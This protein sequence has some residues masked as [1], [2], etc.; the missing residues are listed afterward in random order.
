MSRHRNVRGYNYDE[1][2]EDD[3]MYGQSVDDDY[4]CISPATANQFIY[5]RQ[6]RQPPKEEPLEEEEYEDEDVPMSPTISHNLDPLDQAKLYSCLDHMRTVLGDAVPDSVLSQAAIRYGF[7]SQKALDAVLSEDTK[8]APVKRSTN[9]ETASVAG[10]SQEK[11]PLPQRTKREPVADKGA[12][13]FASHT[14]ITSKAHNP[15]PDGCKHSQ[16]RTPNLHDHLSQ[17]KADL[18]VSSSENLNV[19]RQNVGSGVSSLAQLMSEHEQKSNGTAVVDTGRGLGVPPL[20][21]LAIGPNSPPSTTSNPNSLSLGT[22]ASLNMSSASHSSA[23]SLLSVSL[24]SLSLNCPKLTTAGSSVAAPPGFGNLTSVLQSNPLLVGVATGGKTTVADPKGSPSLAD[25]IQEHSNHSPTISNYFPTPH[26]S[27]ISV[28]CQGMAAPAQTFSLS[29]LASQ[30]QNRSLHIQSQSQSTERLTD[31]LTLSKPPNITATCQGGT[32]SLSQQALQHQTSS[33]LASPQPVNTESTANALKQP[34]GLSELLSLS[35]LASEHKGKTSTTSYGLQFSLTSLLSPAKP[36]RAG[37]LAESTSECGIKCKLDHKSNHQ[38]SRQPNLGQTI[39]LSELMAQSH[40][41]GPR[42]SNND[43]PSLSCPAPGSSAQES[44]VF[45]TPSVFAATL[46]TQ[47][48]RQQ[49]M[50]RNVLKGKIRSQRTGSGYQA[51]LCKSQDNSKEQLTPL[52]PIVPFCFD[53][54]SPDDIVRAN[55]R[56]AFTR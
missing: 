20:S 6:E 38:N 55:Q 43:L 50:T 34:P 16:P 48:R 44:S 37:V 4:C 36:E 15:Q 2:F 41:A 10:V 29:E 19:I 1:D 51:F 23:P 3:D 52:S 7:D 13:L 39:D 54:P 49:K 46:L 30:H 8:T 40:G 9:E 56:K 12:C 5:S 32:V 21:T 45:A 31:T 26:S 18:V 35:H 14:D 24:S 11:A 47:S 42:H 28:R 22:L 17:H 33:S 53:T 25:L 27:G